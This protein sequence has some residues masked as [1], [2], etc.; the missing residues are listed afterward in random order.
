MTICLPLIG[1]LFAAAITPGPNNFIVLERAAH[2][3]VTA[4]IGPILGVIAGS[5]LLL[6]LVWFGISLVESAI[7]RFELF[8]AVTGSAYLAWIGAVLAFKSGKGLDASPR[9]PT[10]TGAVTIFQL[11]NPKAWV[12]VTTAAAA[13]A[14]HG[15]VLVLAALISVIS[16]ICLSL[17]SGLGAALA[18]SLQRSRNRVLF[19][20]VMGALLMFS[21]LGV[22]SDAVR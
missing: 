13:V 10:S 17:W 18:K 15:N 4:A 16:L 1:L 12:L 5:L 20:R 2:S 3:G 11:A 14:A 22:L 6:A 8:I 7:P 21:A 19:D 9:L